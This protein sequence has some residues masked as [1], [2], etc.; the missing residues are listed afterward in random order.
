MLA[1]RKH[2]PTCSIGIAYFPNDGN[3]I[4][5]LLKA[6]DTSLYAAKE[7]GKNCYSFYNPELTRK[8]EYRFLVEQYLRDAI[9]KKQLSLVYQPQIRI[10][11]GEVIGVE[12]LSRWNHPK[13][14]LVPP[15][16]FIPIAERIGMMKP[17]TEW[18]LKTACSQAVSWKN[19]GLPALRVAVNIS[20]NHFLDKK[21]V[22]LVKSVIDET[23]MIPSELELEVT[24]SVVQTNQENLSIFKNLKELGILLAID[25]FGTGYSSFASLNHLK[26]DCLKIDKY[27]IDKIL[28]DKK[29]SLLVNSM[30]DIGHNLEY[31]II[32]EG[33]ETQEQ[34]NL[35]KKYGCETVQG[36]LFS[37]PI[38]ADSI[39]KFINSLMALH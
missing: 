32:A 9:E 23:G 13:L 16:E 19:S 22:T 7:E 3:N 14:G 6:A 1:S 12:V 36:Y 26:V 34:F 2:T 11:T 18:V 5:T 37:K 35:L 30:I 24:E 10:N 33:V 25:D 17:L 20:P 29:T 39:P 21:L 8:T 27:F 28:N 4:S 38:S 15:T 31:G